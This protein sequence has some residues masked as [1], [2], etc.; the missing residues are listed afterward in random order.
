VPQDIPIEASNP[1]AFIPDCLKE[2]DS[3][4][5]FTLRA[6]TWREKE[7]RMRLHREAGIITHSTEAIRAETLN[8]L[9][10]LWTEDQ[11]A[12]YSTFITSLWEAQDQFPARLAEDPDLEWDFDPEIEKAVDELAT[13]IEREWPPLARMAADIDQYQRLAPVFYA[14]VIVKDWSGLPTKRLLD[15]GYLSIDCAMAL[16]EDMIRKDREAG[17]APGM[18]WAQLYSACVDRMY[19][20]EDEAKN[21]ASPSPS[22][23]NPEPSNT[24][25]LQ[26]E[27]GKSPASASSKKTRKSA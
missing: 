7:F 27:S 10:A 24:K 16:C 25:P 19:L 5:A 9:R 23:T 22:E 2:T 1:L 11:F 13:K 3:P 15:R 4:P 8:G 12:E 14:A 21:S 18:S 6:A 26:A 20:S 17:V